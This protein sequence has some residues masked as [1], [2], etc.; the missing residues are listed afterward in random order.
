MAAGAAADFVFF[1]GVG[2]AAGCGDATEGS[3]TELLVPLFFFLCFLP[4]FLRTN[5]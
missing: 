5:L 1:A 2:G 4:S 3:R